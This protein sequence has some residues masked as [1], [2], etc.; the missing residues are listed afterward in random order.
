MNALNC[1]Q[2]HWLVLHLQFT[3]THTK[4]LDTSGIIPSQVLQGQCLPFSA[5]RSSVL[6][7]APPP[8]S[9]S[10]CSSCSAWRADFGAAWSLARSRQRERN[11]AGSV[12]CPP[13]PGCMGG[14]VSACL[15]FLWK[16]T[17]IFTRRG[18]THR[19]KHKK[20]L[21]QNKAWKIDGF[22]RFY[23][24]ITYFVIHWLGH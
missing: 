16:T 18:F 23:L 24:Y 15:D 1:K 12:R 17:K 4:H 20:N 7:T 13:D 6:R 19:E 21:K 11:E 9:Q 5:A 10:R 2:F 8:P 14:M 22:S 3:H